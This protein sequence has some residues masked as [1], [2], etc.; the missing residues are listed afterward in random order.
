MNEKADYTLDFRE[1]IVPLALLKMGQV[2]MEMR[3]NEVLEIITRD[4]EV[5]TDVLKVIP[6]STCEL[7]GVEF[8]KGA[9][10]CRIQLKNRKQSRP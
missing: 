9:Q 8:D 1:T 3:T 10:T 7:L 4:P 2:L 5:R 6:S